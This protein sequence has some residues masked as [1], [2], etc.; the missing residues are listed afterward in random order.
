MGWGELLTQ[1]IITWYANKGKNGDT[2][3]QYPVQLPPEV[4]RVFDESWNVYKA[5]GSPIQREIRSAGQQFIGGIPTT[6]PNFS[7]VSPEM[8][9]QV[10]AGGVTLPKIDFTKPPTSPGPTTP[11]PNTPDPSKPATPVKDMP[12]L[13][14]PQRASLTR[15]ITQEV[16]DIKNDRVEAPRPDGGGTFSGNMYEFGRPR[17]RIDESGEVTPQW[18]D[19][20]TLIGN[21][22]VPTREDLRDAT[23][24]PPAPPLD[25]SGRREPVPQPYT[26]PGVAA[27]VRD[28]WDNYRKSHP[29]W[30]KLG[31][32]AAIGA[33]S[34]VTG[35][36]G[37]VV[38]A[39]IRKSLLSPMVPQGRNILPPGGAGVT[40]PTGGG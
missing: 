19:P 14:Q 25:P 12:N 30:A 35:V 33:I 36:A 6:A 28:A 17:S 21:G 38:G 4:K 24:K 13:T 3:N 20:R 18:R 7:F 11:A 1:A 27:R 39:T 15:D 31:V 2:P 40:P 29:N 26:P 22:G 23:A 16:K 37:S 9:N 8:K 34:A 32:E 5:G 10:F